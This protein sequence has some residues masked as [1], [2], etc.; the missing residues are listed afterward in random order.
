MR[1]QVVLTVRGWEEVSSPR[2]RLVP[3]IVWNACIDDFVLLQAHGQSDPGFP[4][5]QSMGWL[6]LVNVA[7]KKHSRTPIDEVA[8]RDTMDEKKWW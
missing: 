5:E 8:W 6:Q 7:W 2:G 1:Q 3:A 4:T